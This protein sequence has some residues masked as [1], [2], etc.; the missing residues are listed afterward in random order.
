[1]TLERVIT[2]LLECLEATQE[3]KATKKP[4]SRAL[5]W[6]WKTVNREEEKE[7]NNEQIRQNKS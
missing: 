7:K 5:Y 2:I 3:D 6:T 1:M 4:Y